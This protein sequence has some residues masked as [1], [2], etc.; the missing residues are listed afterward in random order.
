LRQNEQKTQK[1]KAGGLQI[2]DVGGGA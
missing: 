1:L 2:C